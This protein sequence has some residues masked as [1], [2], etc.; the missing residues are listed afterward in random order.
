M[1]AIIAKASRVAEV[2]TRLSRFR[3]MKPMQAAMR[4]A[5]DIV[6]LSLDKEAIV[7]NMFT[8]RFHHQN[9]EE[10]YEIAFA[11]KGKS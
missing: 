3:Q 11:S 9:D 10:W 7:N 1:Q 6:D 5:G 8:C 2:K 4:I